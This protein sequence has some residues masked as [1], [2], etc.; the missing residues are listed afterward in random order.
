MKFLASLV[1]KDVANQ[2][3]GLFAPGF[4]QDSSSGE[5]L[6][7]IVLELNRNG[8]KLLS[9]LEFCHEILHIGKQGLKFFWLLI[10]LYCFMNFRLQLCPG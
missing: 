10:K 8:V 7:S 9:T 2:L 6:R 3:K 4:A 5:K 1:L